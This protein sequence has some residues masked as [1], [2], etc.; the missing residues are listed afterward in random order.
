MHGFPKKIISDNGKEFRKKKKKLEQFC[1]A[2][3]ITLAHGAPNT[4]NTR[5]NRKKQQIL[6][7]GIRAIIIDTADKDIK[8]WCQYTKQAAYT[9]NMLYHRAIK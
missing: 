5:F 2:N 6:E 7:V 9:R 1:D 4:D 8:R 3:R